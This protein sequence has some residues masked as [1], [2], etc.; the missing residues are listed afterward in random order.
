MQARCTQI[1]RRRLGPCDK[2]ALRRGAFVPR[3]HGDVVTLDQCFKAGD[4][5]QGDRR[6]DHPELGAIDQVILGQRVQRQLGA[7][8]GQI[9]IDLERL[10][11]ADLN[12]FVHHRRA[13]SLQAFEVGQL[14]LDLDPG[15]S[16]VEVFIQTERQARI[17]RRAVLAVF[18]R[19][20]RN[21][22]SHNTGQG[23]T[24][25]FYPGQVGVDADAAGV[26]EARVFAHQLGVGR[27][28][29]DLEFNRTLIFGKHV[30]LD[31]P[32]LDLLVEHRAATV[33]RAQAIG[34]DRQVQAWLG[35]G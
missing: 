2:L 33:Q 12:A 10:E 8:T 9:G 18:R 23:L 3:T 29:E 21:T 25:Y 14:D 17:G 13:A 34:L 26:P 19:G 5:R 20:K 32:D 15:G 30:A 7:G 31:L 1:Q 16:G 35:V 24:A 4:A 22:A 27:L 11:G 6:L 28:D